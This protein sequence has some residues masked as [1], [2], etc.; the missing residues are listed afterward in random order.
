MTVV[1]KVLVI[2]CLLLSV[3]TCGM[4]ALVFVTRTNWKTEYE[5]MRN[6]ALVAEAAYKTEKQAHETD[7]KAHEGRE[8]AKDNENRLL[9]TLNN[10][11]AEEIKR[12]QAQIAV[13][14]GIN[15][16]S[17]TTNVASS[18]EL[19]QQKAERDLLAKDA[20]EARAFLLETQKKLNEQTLAATTQKIEADTQRQRANQLLVRVED[21]EKN[22]IQA[23]N[24]LT[25][26]GVIAAGS[27]DTSLLNRQPSPA[28]RDVKGTVMVVNAQGL[29]VVNIGSDSGISAGN[30]LYVYQMDP[31]VFLGE[32]VVSRTEP[33]QAVGQFKPKPFAKPN[34]RLPKQN[35]I[36][37]TSLGG[38]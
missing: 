13:E 28:P 29:M 19:L 14:Q 2:M 21:L 26:L 9:S 32:M 18:S 36:V 23:T 24:K 37:S 30:K 6:V 4:I 15:K 8:E 34:E 3:L 7:N 38:R 20:Q 35:D 27:S 1:G 5:K 10:T 11:Q 22:L 17:Q 12:Q 31:P 33:K 25:S 16:T